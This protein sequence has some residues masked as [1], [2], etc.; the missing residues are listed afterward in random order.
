MDIGAAVARTGL[1]V[2][3]GDVSLFEDML[4]SALE[5]NP[6]SDENKEDLKTHYK[7]YPSRYVDDIVKLRNTL[8]QYGGAQAVNTTNNLVLNL[9]ELSLSQK[10][11]LLN[12]KLSQLGI[13]EEMLTGGR[14]RIPEDAGRGDCGGTK[15]SGGERERPFT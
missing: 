2:Q 11:K 8:P 5:V 4:T 6:F 12:E 7:S 3:T 13:T 9:G 1:L 15:S 10:E 14:T